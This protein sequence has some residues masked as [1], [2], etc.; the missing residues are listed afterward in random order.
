MKSLLKLP[1]LSGLFLLLTAGWALSQ[2]IESADKT[3]SPYF[4]VQ[5][6]DPDVD[7][8]PLKSTSAQVKI[9]VSL[10]ITLLLLTF[11]SDALRD[12]VDQRKAQE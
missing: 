10:V 2:G 12:A 8:L 11:M 5:G 6:G 4:V 3:L 9:A 7:G 1:V